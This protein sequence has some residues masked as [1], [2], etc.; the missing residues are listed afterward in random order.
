MISS[1]TTRI[2]AIFW[3]TLALVLMLVLM[4]PK[5]DSRQMTS[6]LESEQRQG[7]MIEQ[8]VEAELGHDPPNDLMWWRRLFRAIDKWAPPGQRLLLVTSE[9]RVIGAQHNE[10]QI[11]RNFIGQ[12]DNSDHPQ[13]KK[14]GRVELVGPFSVRDGEDNYQLYLIRP[15]GSS[16]LDFINLLFDRPLLLLIVTMLIS[17]PLLLWLAWSLAKPAR[18]LK[19]AA[20]EVASGN[21]RQHPELEAGP[22][23]FLAAGSSFNQMVSAL[24]RMMTAQQR[25]LS[26]ISHELRTP[27]TRL[28]LAT[29]LMRRRHGE[30]KELQRIEM[31]A[32][33]LDG[34]INDLLV[35]SRTQHKNA[36]VSE[37]MKANQL[38]A[39]VLDDAKFEAEQMGKTLEV[40]YP[41]GPWP[42]Y[43]NP[44]ALDSA[45][46]NIV[47]N[48]LR[49]SH[50]RISVSFS[51]DNQGITVHVDDDGPGVSAEDREQ[52]F[53]PFYRTDEA[54]DRE[55][56][57]T[58][59]GLAIVE[60][61]I[62]QHRGWVKADD[63]PLGGLRLTI[64]LPLYSS[65]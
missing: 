48:A 29:A 38:W 63:S 6:L 61:A 42:L 26:D 36:L 54:R 1:L 27:L 47:R 30:G 59:L 10:M 25:L 41:P 34:M 31:E 46:E 11:I 2:F 64:W 65:R 52:I 32:Q 4:V 35:L 39:G 22:Q 18:K 16:Q 49:Y 56:G 8:H 33:R 19:H 13:K 51:V 58:G 53:R 28:Q 62:Q 3:L 9:G 12:S 15:A 50:T 21:L 5:L 14:Y 7:I 55:S 45:L 44:N 40:P 43:G 17:S 24:E 37:A 23:E 57:G 20:D 60:T